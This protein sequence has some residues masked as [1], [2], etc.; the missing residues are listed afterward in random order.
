MDEIYYSIMDSFVLKIILT[1]KMS[2]SIDDPYRSIS[3][4]NYDLALITE[5]L[6]APT[7][8]KLHVINKIRYDV[9]LKKVFNE[10]FF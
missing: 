10:Y 6:S 8:V 5:I 1:K 7:P 4:K 9:R 3:K 2:Q